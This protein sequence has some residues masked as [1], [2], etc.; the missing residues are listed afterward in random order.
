[1][2]LQ[3]IQLYLL[4]KSNNKLGCSENYS[5]FSRSKNAW[6]LSGAFIR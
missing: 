3:Y 5:R 1:M 4:D 2:Q 6:M